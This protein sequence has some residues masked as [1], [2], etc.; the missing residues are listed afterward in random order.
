MN[1]QVR[2][3]YVE[4]DPLQ[5]ELLRDYFSIIAPEFA[6]TTVDD[7]YG[8]LQFLRSQTFDV[9]LLDYALPDWNGLEVLRK[10]IQEGYLLPVVMLTGAGNEEIVVQALRI[11][12]SDYITKSQHNI[13][14]LPK[15]LHKAI[16]EFQLKRTTE[17]TLLPSPRSILFVENYSSDLDNTLYKFKETAPHFSFTIASD[18]KEALNLIEKNNFFDLVLT[19]LRLP[20]VSGLELLREVK[21]RGVHIPFIIITARGD[22]ETAVSALKLG[23]YDYVV[24]RDNYLAQ[25]PYS[26]ENAISRY[27]LQILNSKLNEELKERKSAE[28]A[29]RKLSAYLQSIREEERTNIAREIHDEL[30]QALTGLKMDLVWMTRRL[31]SEQTILT[32]KISSMK[33]IIDETIQTVRKI[34]T[35]LRPSSLDDLGLVAT[36]EWQSQE[37]QNRTGITC[38]FSSNHENLNLARE[39]ATSVFRIFQETLTNVARHAEATQVSISLIKTSE[40]LQLVVH[41]NGKGISS[42]KL[43]NTSSL[44]LLGIRERAAAFGGNVVFESENGNGTKVNVTIPMAQ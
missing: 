2:L 40:E 31:T 41:D 24:K 35:E 9:I 6:V 27:Q 23:A 4:D 20:D 11:G 36:M 15:I 29:L 42:E 3:L 44:G 38:T 14:G 1:T 8:C 19:D 32:D 10:I 25:L 18:A 13:D 5:T 39:L 12:A 43:L 30:G 17:A 28:D 7:G 21:Q 26:I 33:K 37:F 16:H 34:A 22:E